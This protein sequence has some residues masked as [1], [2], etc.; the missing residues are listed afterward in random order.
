MIEYDFDAQWSTA[1]CAATDARMVSFGATQLLM[2]MMLKDLEKSVM[3]FPNIK[4]EH[5]LIRHNITTT[6]SRSE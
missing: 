3:P 1:D 4:R 2:Y 6:D 5:I